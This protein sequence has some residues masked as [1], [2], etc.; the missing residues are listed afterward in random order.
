ML[1]VRT[2]EG[3]PGKIRVTGSSDGLKAGEAVSEA[4]ARLSILAFS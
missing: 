2:K 4:V 1:I 3:S